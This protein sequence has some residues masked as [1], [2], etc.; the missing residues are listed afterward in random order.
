VKSDWTDAAVK[1]ETQAERIEREAELE[2]QRA[3]QKAEQKAKSAKDKMAAEAK[4]AKAT[5]KKDGQKLADNRDNP[6]VIG[7]ALLWTITAVAVGYGAYQ[8]HAEG[9][10]DWKLAGTVAGGLGALAVGDYFASSYVFITI[11]TRCTWSLTSIRWLLENKYP[12]K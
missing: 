2:A 11:S 7:N 10:L 6:V 9:K 1:T 4:K 3:S 8:K 5:L 12:P